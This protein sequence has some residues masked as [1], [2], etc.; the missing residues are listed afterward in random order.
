MAKAQGYYGER[1]TQVF[2]SGSLGKMQI[3]KQR[4]GEPLF[5]RG[6]LQRCAVRESIDRDSTT[7]SARTQPIAMSSTASRPMVEA[8]GCGATSL[9][10]EFPSQVTD[11][12]RCAGAQ[13]KREAV[14]QLELIWGWIVVRRRLEFGL[15]ETEL[16]ER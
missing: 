14:R 9:C 16:V 2:E 1:L 15:A 11:G 6:H 12:N 8:G 3:V 10:R 13:I 4:L 7:A 5:S